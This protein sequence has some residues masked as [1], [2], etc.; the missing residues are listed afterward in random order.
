MGGYY[1]TNPGR[2]G[3]GL[4]KGSPGHEFQKLL[5]DTPFKPSRERPGHNEF[6]DWLGQQPF[7]PKEERP[8]KP[9]VPPVPYKPSP[10]P[11]RPPGPRFPN[12]FKWN[13]AWK[14][15]QFALNNF[16]G[17]HLPRQNPG[18]IFGPGW[19]HVCGDMAT[20]P[21]LGFGDKWGLAPGHT[22]LCGTTFQVP[23]GY[24]PLEDVVHDN[25][26]AQ[27]MMGPGH[28]FADPPA[29]RYVIWEVW[30]L[31]AG[32]PDSPIIPRPPRAPIAP[33]VPA[34]PYHLPPELLP[35][36]TMAPPAPY[37]PR[38]TSKFPHFGPT[39]NSESGP[40]QEPKPPVV[41]WP[42][43]PSPP[44]PYIP[45]GPGVKE[46][47]FRFADNWLYQFATWLMG[48]ITELSDFVD[49]LWGAMPEGLQRRY[50]NAGLD[51]KL[52][53]IYDNYQQ[54]DGEKLVEG[55]IKDWLEDAAIGKLGQGVADAVK[56]AAKNGLYVS[57]KGLQFKLGDLPP[58]EW[59]PP[60]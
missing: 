24:L 49:V 15:F 43:P 14:A 55:L 29:W 56:K 10:K 53:I 57:P 25:G 38:P 58:I 4:S 19:Y 28:L 5:R 7:K 2:G 17:L 40:K 34:P 31:D 39:E 20:A 37:P 11:L 50:A 54:I 27:F 1:P 32:D 9:A 35:P 41:G 47:K 16:P 33:P 51:T 3:P 23:D 59:T 13:P 22:V 18:V 45:A 8:R 48:L 36:G 52:K 60:T 42:K 30:R 6:K 44:K 12:P 26:P 46:K 21:D